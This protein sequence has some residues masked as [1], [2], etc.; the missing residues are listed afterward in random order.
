[1]V[2]ALVAAPVLVLTACGG[3]DDSLDDRL[4]LADPKVRLV[5]AAPLAPNVTL[6]RNDLTIAAD[7]TNVP[8]KGASRYFDVATSTERWDVRTAT[9]PA[10]NVGSS[11][12]D[13]RRGTR[14]TLV[15][16]PDANSITEVA[17][18]SDPYNKG[19]TSDNARVRVYNASANA[20]GVDVYLTAPATDIATVAP[21]FGNVG[22][23]QAVPASGNDSLE[24]EGGSYR[25]RMTTAGT[26][27]VIF[28]ATVELAKNADWLLTSVPGSLTPND[29]RVLVV[30][31]DEGAP[32]V[33]L[34]NTP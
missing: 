30:K 16:L 21:N 26:K 2:A 11:T 29:V 14:Y 17:L 32:A 18:I 22:Y 10:L 28:N 8:Y 31:S 24:V 27:N 9:T 33:E 3:G 5:H 6:F 12:F 25:V 15:A 1:M 34:V 13:A 20:G 4:D 7:V 23:K 19:I